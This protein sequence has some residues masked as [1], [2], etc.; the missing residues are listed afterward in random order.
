MPC[1][2][3]PGSP[4]DV[5]RLSPMLLMPSAADRCDAQ[6]GSSFGLCEEEL[7]KAGPDVIARS[8]EHGRVR[9]ALAVV[10]K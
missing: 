3:L 6:G 10:V 9:Q 2:N 7:K 1:L 4:R 8:T 5:D